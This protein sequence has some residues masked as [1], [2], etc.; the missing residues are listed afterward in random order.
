MERHTGRER[1]R[2]WDLGQRSAWPAPR[3]SSP[4]F[5]PRPAAEGR[6]RS[7]SGWAETFVFELSAGDYHLILDGYEGGDDGDF[8]L[9]IDWAPVGCGNGFLEE[10]EACD[11]G[12]RVGGDG[13]SADCGTTS[14]H[15]LYFDGGLDS[16]EQW[17]APELDLDDAFTI[18][19]WFRY[20]GGSTS[21]LF[22]IVFKEWGYA[23]YLLAVWEGYLF[24]G[25]RDD[26]DEVNFE[27]AIDEV[28]I[29]WGRLY[30]SPFTP[31]HRMGVDTDTIVLFHFDEGAG[32]VTRPEPPS[33]LVALVNGCDWIPE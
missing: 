24:G 22:P 27:G 5:W 18:E 9:D 32:R 26:W 17:A 19:A 10:G 2:R 3:R 16:V 6:R 12:N 7:S 13:C 23:T 25:A 21:R 1:R 8:E 30:W 11:D 31:D 4:A 14:P 20:D 28:R 29:S 15:A 33:D